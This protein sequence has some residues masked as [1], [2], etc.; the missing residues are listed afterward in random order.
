MYI[1]KVKFVTIDFN[2][3]TFESVFEA[4]KVMGKSR[5]SEDFFCFGKL[6]VPFKLFKVTARKSHSGKNVYCDL[7]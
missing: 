5:D 4:M 6:K 3:L 7:Q 2:F 1:L